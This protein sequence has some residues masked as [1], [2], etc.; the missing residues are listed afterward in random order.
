[1]QYQ[2]IIISSDVYLA[3]Q[4]VNTEYQLLAILNDKVLLQNDESIR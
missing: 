2:S 3:V 1:M 4:M